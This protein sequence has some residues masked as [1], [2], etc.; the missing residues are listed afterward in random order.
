[1]RSN[2]EDR[3]DAAL[4]GINDPIERDQVKQYIIRI[5]R[6][7]QAAIEFEET[8]PEGERYTG[9]KWTRSRSV[10]Y[11]DQPPL[12]FNTFF[13]EHKKE[14]QSELINDTNNN[15][16]GRAPTTAVSVLIERHNLTR[17]TVRYDYY[18]TEDQFVQ[19]ESHMNQQ[20]IVDSPDYYMQIWHTG[21]IPSNS[22]SPI[23]VLVLTG[24][25]KGRWIGRSEILAVD[26]QIKH[27]ISSRIIG[28]RIIKDPRPKR[29]KGSK[30]FKVDR[31][32]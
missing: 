22:K 16:G 1:M 20:M 32:I 4:K 30:W 31:D 19:L 5:L 24:C 21:I 15:G 25:P 3:I 14:Y 23:E 28:F 11:G 13:N 29:D 27:D 2:P 17:E 18:P 26:R 10:E 9:I 12:D 6:Q 8:K 7:K